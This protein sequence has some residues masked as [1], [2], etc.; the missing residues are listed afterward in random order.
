MDL[1]LPGA[2][3]SL[4]RDLLPRTDAD[5]LMAAL[6]ESLPWRQGHIRIQGRDIPEPRLTSWHGNAGSYSYSGRTLQENPWTEALDEIRG[7]IRDAIGSEF[8]SVLANLFSP[9]APSSA[10]AGRIPKGESG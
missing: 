3:V 4:H 9:S 5:R 1:H 6:T 10:E 2:D 7:R 8:N